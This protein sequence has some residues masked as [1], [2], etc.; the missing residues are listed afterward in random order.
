MESHVS[1]SEGKA[2]YNVRGLDKRERRCAGPGSSE[3]PELEAGTALLQGRD[4]PRLA[5][6]GGGLCGASG[7]SLTPADGQWLPLDWQKGSLAP[8]PAALSVS[9]QGPPL[10]TN[11]PFLP[12]PSD[13]RSCRGPGWAPPGPARRSAGAS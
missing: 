12:C 9:G 3:G 10:P 1:S 2:R 4:Q 8:W 13:S 6:R 5:A 7:A 11:P